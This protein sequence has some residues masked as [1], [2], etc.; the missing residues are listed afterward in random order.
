MDKLYTI[1]TGAKTMRSWYEKV[2]K[3]DTAFG[4]INLGKLVHSWFII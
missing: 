3:L 4:N 1:S 2:I